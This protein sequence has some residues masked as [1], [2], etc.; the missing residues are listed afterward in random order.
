MERRGVRRDLT[1]R[2]LHNAPATT[3]RPL[4]L[5]TS[6]IVVAKR[7]WKRARQQ[8]FANSFDSRQGLIYDWQHKC[9]NLRSYAFTAYDWSTAETAYTLARPRRPPVQV[10][11]LPVK[12]S[13]L[14]LSFGMMRNYSENDTV[15]VHPFVLETLRQDQLNSSFLAGRR[16]LVLTAEEELSMDD[17][18]STSIYAVPENAIDCSQHIA[19]HTRYTRLILKDGKSID[20]YKHNDME[21]V[22]GYLTSSLGAAASSADPASQDQDIPIATRGELYAAI[23]QWTLEYRQRYGAKSRIGDDDAAAAD[24]GYEVVLNEDFSLC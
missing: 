4:H 19:N 3:S 1:N 22:V 8:D 6:C 24:D 20:Q 15:Y 10:F 13:F 11:Q 7:K 12:Q 23:K 16:V 21:E 17:S 14:F 2:E 5:A 9:R 18:L